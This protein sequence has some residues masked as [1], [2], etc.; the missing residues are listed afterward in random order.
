MTYLAH[1]EKNG[2]PAQSYKEHIK[3]VIKYATYFAEEMAAYSPQHAELIK[4]VMRRTAELHDLGKLLK[5]NQ[6]ALHKKGGKKGALPINHVDAGVAYLKQLKEETIYSCLVIQGH[7][8]G[9]PNYAAE[10][11]RINTIRFRDNREAVRTAVDKELEKMIQIHKELIPQIEV[12]MQE[13]CTGNKAI[14][15]R[16]L[17]SCL[18]DADYSDTANAYGRELN[19]EHN[20]ELKPELRLETLDRYV[21][22]LQN[23]KQD[24]RSQLRAQ[25]YTLCRNCELKNGIV[26][27]DAPVGSGKT[28]AVMAYQL[29]QAAGVGAR[30]IFVIL[31]YTNIITQSV[32]I[33]RNALVLPGEN[34]EEVVAEVHSRVDFE[35]ENTRYLSALWR[36]PI[37]V[38]TA[39]AFFETLASNKPY[40]LRRLHEL[41]GSIIFID[42]AHAALPLHLLPIAWDWMQVLNKEWGCHWILASGSLVRFWNVKKLIQTEETYVPEMINQEIRE[43]LFDYE[44]NRIKFCWKK[45]A[46]SRESLIKCVMEAKGPRLLIMNTVRNAAVIAADISKKYGKECVEHLSTALAPAER[47][48]TMEVI[49][50][51]LSNPNDINWVLVATS[52]V[53][54]GVDFSFHTGFREMAS[55]VSLLQSAGRVNRSG[56]Y[57]DSEMW[58][59][60]MQDDM[61]L[62]VNPKIEVSADILEEYLA[63]GEKITPELSTEAIKQQLNRSITERAIIKKL[64]DEEKAL[65]FKNVNELFCVI[66]ETT[67]QVI[68]NDEVAEQIRQGKGSWREVQK[69]SVAI[70]KKYM[71][72]QYV[73]NIKGDVYHWKLEYN[74]FLGYMAGLLK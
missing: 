27:N 63:E 20:I 15:L 70:P 39:V 2:Y 22:T 45:K 28:T 30:R 73:E 33:Y 74:S 51:R 47:Q 48:I 52:C 53:E 49:R 29:R 25:V 26:S 41:A 58:S 7:H 61:M 10:K 24:K 21:K 12:D 32:E 54:A 68:V 50:K 5:E 69:H 56:F 44:K 59:F 67:V 4:F 18:A 17:M 36:A 66:E 71:N 38:T 65:G 1:S 13:N 6:E 35:D 3:N 72:Q 16:M 42:E 57:E 40:I 60:C 62:S 9:L 37:V 8:H 11:S 55:V 34:P 14:F 43:V 19:L 46:Q 31:P 23:N 64:K